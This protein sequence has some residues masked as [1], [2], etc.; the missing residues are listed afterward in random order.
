MMKRICVFLLC[1]CLLLASGCSKV[2]AI[3]DDGADR[4]AHGK[5]EENYGLKNS[6]ALLDDLIDRFSGSYQMPT[7]TKLDD[8]SYDQMDPGTDSVVPQVGSWN[9]LLS[10]FHDV[11]RETGDYVTFDLVGGYTIDPDKDLQQVFNDLQREDPIYVS[12][13]KQWFWGNRG[14]RY[15]FAIDYTMDE[16]ELKRIKSETEALVDRAVA[17]IDTTGKSDYELVCAVNDYL[18]DTVYYPDEPYPAMS[19]T[20]YGAL[21]DGVAVCEGYACAAK[22]MLNKMG[23]F[24]DIQVGVCTGGGGHAWNLVQLEGQWYQ[25]DVTWND[26]GADRTDYLLVTDAYMQKSRSWDMSQYPLCATE[27]YTP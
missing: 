5:Q 4:F 6:G 2:P 13:V 3:M 27:P 16:G 1:L 17:A 11:Y 8:S 10:V 21:H 12:C 18:C 24:C 14:D 9:D 26:G 22:L 20:A 19:H 15:V 7:G 23:I 25:L